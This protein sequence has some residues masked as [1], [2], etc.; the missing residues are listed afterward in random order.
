MPTAKNA[1]ALQVEP[2]VGRLLSAQKNATAQH[3]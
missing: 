3:R 1:A 2:T